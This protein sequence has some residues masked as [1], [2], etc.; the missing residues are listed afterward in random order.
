M[1]PPYKLVVCDIDG[2]L[3]DDHKKISLKNREA[4]DLF[5]EQGGEISL[6]TGRIEKSVAAYCRELEI[7]VPIIL[8]N[9]AKIFHPLTGEVIRELCLSQEEVDQA[10]SMM[11]NFPLDFIFYS[12]GEAYIL[13]SSQAVRQYE[14]GDGFLCEIEQDIAVIRQK[15]ITKILI[16]GNS[17]FF[18]G[19]RETFTANPA[20]LANLVQS[21]ETYL[22]ILPE[23]VNK[24]A[25][26]RV[27]AEHLGLSLKEVICFGDNLND[28]EMIQIAGVGVAMGNGRQEVQDSADIVAPRNTDDGVGTVLQSLMKVPI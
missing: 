3:V 5:R 17:S 28:L 12:G 19:F 9:G 11:D 10:V 21:E 2:T 26:L 7:K 18:L 15:R 27:L 25:A 23:G 16:I 4:M 14:K 13:R 1:N 22:E 6:A 20:C 8:Y 24:G